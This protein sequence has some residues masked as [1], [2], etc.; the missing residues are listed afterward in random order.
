VCGY[1]KVESGLSVKLLCGLSTL[2]VLRRR[3]ARFL[4]E[5]ASIAEKVVMQRYCLMWVLVVVMVWGLVAAAKVRVDTVPLSQIPVGKVVS[6]NG[7]KFVKIGD[8]KYMAVEPICG[9]NFNGQSFGYTGNAQT[10]TV[11]CA[12]VYKIELWGAGG[13]LRADVT[14]GNVIYKGAYVSG[15]LQ[16]ARGEKIYIYLGQKGMENPTSSFNGGGL[17]STVLYGGGGASDMRLVDG[18]WNTAAGERSRILVAGAGGGGSYGY[19]DGNGA[20]GGNAGGLMGY[21]GT[22]YAGHGNLSQY[23]GG[24]TQVAG[25]A[26]G[27]NIYGATGDGTAGSF[28]S[29]GNAAGSSWPG[30]GGGGYYG[31]GAGGGTAAGGSGN[32]GGGGSS[33]ISGHTGCVAITSVSDQTPKAGCTTGTSDNACSVH[34][35]GKVFTNTV[36]ID[37]AGYAWT[38]VK[39]NLKPMPNP[40]GGNYA[41]GVGH[42]GNGAARITRL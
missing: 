2:D 32:G 3:V 17:G 4:F 36:M 8:N 21:G 37:G 5:K 33:Y 35:S 9:A 39:G 19:Y 6:V 27:N 30:S 38:N 20:Q 12:G 29:G 16:L 25:G 18:A 15:D 1:T 42:A 7:V 28:G 34:Y 40:A 31:G 14:N 41:G 13:A 23:G 22:Y 11:P 26:L 24:G 10:F